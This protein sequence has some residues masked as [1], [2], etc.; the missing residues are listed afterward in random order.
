MC[1]ICG[2]NRGG[3]KFSGGECV[4][5]TS[6]WSVSRRRGVKR[7]VIKRRRAKQSEEK[8]QKEEEKQMIDAIF[9]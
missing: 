7:S 3:A 9:Y 1:W 6:E 8:E 4:G 5:W 2:T